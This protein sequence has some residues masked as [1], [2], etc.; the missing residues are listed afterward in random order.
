MRIEKQE[1]EKFLLTLYWDSIDNNKVAVAV[2][3]NTQI[4]LSWREL[5]RMEVEH[6]IELKVVRFDYM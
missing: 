4:T 1:W 6:G 5:R 3:R 2:Y